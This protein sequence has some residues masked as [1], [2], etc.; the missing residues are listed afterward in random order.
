MAYYRVSLGISSDIIICRIK[1]L[2]P[3][4]GY[5]HYTNGQYRIPYSQLQ[6][7]GTKRIEIGLAF[8][9]TIPN[10]LLVECVSHSYHLR[11]CWIG[12]PVS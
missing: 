9:T 7:A 4:K 6:G 11:L 3:K 10:E 8:L 5:M 12:G 1:V 2:F